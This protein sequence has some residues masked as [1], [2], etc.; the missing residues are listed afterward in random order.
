MGLDI[1]G[2]RDGS[3]SS[4]GPSKQKRKF[5]DMDKATSIVSSQDP[6]SSPSYT[7]LLYRLGI[8]EEEGVG[9][10]PP[11]SGEHQIHHFLQSQGISP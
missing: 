5:S 11:D 10:I 2:F 7:T 4:S 1:N 3:P 9:T 6:K 8:F